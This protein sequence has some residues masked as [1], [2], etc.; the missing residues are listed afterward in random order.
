VD[1]DD[2]HGLVG[3]TL[4]GRFELLALIGQGGMG[5]VYRARDR[6]LDELVALKVIRGE[7]ASQPEVLARF[8]H[9]VKLARRVT[10][11]NV[12][13]IFEAGTLDGIAFFTMEL[14]EGEPLSA[15]LRSGG[16]LPASRAVAIAIDVL[17]GL[18]AAHAAGIIHRDIK[19]DNL[20]VDHDGRVVVTDFG[21]AATRAV[22]SDVIAGT[23]IY[24]APEQAEG[25]LVTAAADVYAVGVVLAEMLTGAAPWSGTT[26]EILTAK[27][28]RPQL[29]IA[30]PGIEPALAVVLARATATDPRARL[31]AADEL[32]ALLV[33]WAAP[34]QHASARPRRRGDAEL[35]DVIVHHPRGA[36]HDDGHLAEALY[37]A[38]VSRLW[39]THRVRVVTDGRPRE[40]R[41]APAAEI[42]IELADVLAARA[43]DG[44]GRELVLVRLPPT[45]EHLS[46]GA[47]AI[48]TAVL[49]ALGVRD[50]EAAGEPP[51]L[52]LDLYL[53]ARSLANRL[54]GTAIAAAIDLYDQALALADGDARIAAARAM[55]L[56]RRVYYDSERQ[57]AL[58]EATTAVEALLGRRPDLPEIQIAAGHLE[59]HRGDPIAAAQHLRRAIASA[60][61]LAEAHEWLGRMLLEAG[62]L[63]EG[64]ARLETALAL[65]PR[66]ELARWEIARAHAL[67]G[68]WDEYDR[69]A[70]ELI[71]VA[72]MRATPWTARFAAWRGDLRT[73]A[74]IATSASS[75]VLDTGLGKELTGELLALVNDR[76]WTLHGPRLVALAL[77]G[78]TVSSRRR[79]LM[80]QLVAEMAG[81]FGDTT[82]I[83]R[84]V[85]RAVAH[86]FFDRHWLERC[87]LLD[88]ARDAGGLTAARAAVQVRARRILDA[89]YGDG[90]TSRAVADTLVAASSTDLGAE[91]GVGAPTLPGKTRL[92]GG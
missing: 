23:P 13:R 47:R 46:T 64:R 32:R 24:M 55:A 61:H 49:A 82:S 6:E 72:R 7:V 1:G 3:R 63:D 19:P 9:E 56:S 73:F 57:G 87:P 68:D 76:D 42:S 44:R 36:D 28:A 41:G 21:I 84:L 31:G 79:C 48:A 4:G 51:G 27:R 77:H 11:R 60:P 43:V 69:V 54:S 90:D 86:G 14:V 2:A 65:D 10:H 17:D 66:L 20:L 26:R 15:R 59:L 16:R 70:R 62:H 92:G 88:R 53:R 45:A 37:D 38:V 81:Q 75:V 78:P 91:L 18:G 50:D 33:P 80:C 58:D 67:E 34:G 30:G 89:L 40:A 39:R 71:G 29:E 85:D 52:A 22:A 5:A 74:E 25:T 8:R 12:A 83:V 35:H